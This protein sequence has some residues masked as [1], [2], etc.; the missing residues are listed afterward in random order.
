MPTAAAVAKHNTKTGNRGGNSS[1][2]PLK[3]S[4]QYPSLLFNLFEKVKGSNVHVGFYRGV[5]H[6]VLLCRH[7]GMY[8]SSRLTLIQVSYSLTWGGGDVFIK[9]E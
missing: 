5:D 1:Q 9:Q 4:N 7:E 8:K 2:S 3:F 6:R